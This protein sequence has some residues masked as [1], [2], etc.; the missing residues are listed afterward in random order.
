MG[1]LAV[2]C[3]CP[4]CPPRELPGVQVPPRLWVCL[5]HSLVKQTQPGGSGSVGSVPCSLPVLELLL[6]SA[7]SSWRWHFCHCGCTSGSCSSPSLSS[8][9][10]T[11]LCLPC[12]CLPLLPWHLGT[13]LQR[14]AC[15]TRSEPLLPSMFDGSPSLAGSRECSDPG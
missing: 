14:A 5:I 11:P 15:P 3:V 9:A 2:P 12:P 4:S 8:V 10:V 13:C 7:C 6:S 1:F